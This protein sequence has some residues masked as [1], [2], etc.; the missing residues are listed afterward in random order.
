MNPFLHSIVAGPVVKLGTAVSPC[1][2]HGISPCAPHGILRP[3]FDL[4][5]PLI[6]L[7]E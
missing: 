3:G 1:A 2:P 5:H 4:I 6:L 7:Q